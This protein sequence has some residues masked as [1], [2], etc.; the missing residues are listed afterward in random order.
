MQPRIV[1]F[2]LLNPAREI[3]GGTLLATM[4]VEFGCLIIAGARLVLDLQNR[5]FLQMPQFRHSADRIVLRRGQERDELL[6]D[7]LH[8]LRAFAARPAALPLATASD[9]PETGTS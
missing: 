1:G 8:K 9:D 5:P 2:R 4:S 6:A 3:G 7:A